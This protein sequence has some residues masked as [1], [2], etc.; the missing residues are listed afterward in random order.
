MP[1]GRVRARRARFDPA[2]AEDI[3]ASTLDM[4]GPPFTPYER[5][6]PYVPGRRFAADFA[7]L[8]ER[9]LVEVQG[10]IAAFVRDDGE[11]RRGAHGSVSGVIKDLERG[12]LATLHGWRVLRFMPQAM[13][14]DDIAE[15]VD[16]I[17]RALK[18]RA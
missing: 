4:L 10:G 13:R 15:T 5:Q 8:A 11:E 9:L 18:W 3:L 7:F 16:V 1:H 6:Y 2:D 12:N 17:E 14:E